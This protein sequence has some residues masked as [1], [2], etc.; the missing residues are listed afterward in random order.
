MV[1]S[2]KKCSYKIRIFLIR[3]RNFFLLFAFNPFLSTF[4]I[5]K[6][7]E[8]SC[9]KESSKVKILDIKN[10]PNNRSSSIHHKYSEDSLKKKKKSEDNC[11]SK[12]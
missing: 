10:R 9:S 2:S 5:A 1:I 6:V 12:A 7:E 4:Y 3:A 8:L 11:S